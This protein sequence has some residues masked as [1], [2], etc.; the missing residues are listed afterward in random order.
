MIRASWVWMAVGNCTR[1]ADEQPGR[2]IYQKALTL[3]T[4]SVHVAAT[5][6]LI[7]LAGCSVQVQQPIRIVRDIGACDPRVPSPLP[8]PKPRSV[9][10]IAAWGNQTSLALEVANSRLTECE[11][12]RAR[13]VQALEA[14]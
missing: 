14:R 13:A 1:L 2:R 11:Q 8:P 7:L 3:S 10:T 6:L 4:C 5:A 9:E 12:R